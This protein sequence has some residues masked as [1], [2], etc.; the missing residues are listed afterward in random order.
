MAHH[1]V[2]TRNDAG[3]RTASGTIEHPHR[4]DPRRFGDSV[5]CRCDGSG[6]VRTVPVTVVAAQSRI[7]RRNASAKVRMIRLHARVDDI[8]I[9][10][11]TGA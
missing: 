9:Y 8:Y 5:C 6:H 1:P 3:I 10:V 11:C 2:D 4:N 7:P